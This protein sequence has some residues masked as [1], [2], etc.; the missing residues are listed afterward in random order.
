MRGKPISDI[1][2]LSIEVNGVYNLLVNIN[3]HKATGP[4]GIPSRLLKET[5]YQM[6]PLLTFIFQSSLDQGK[7]PCDWKLANITPLYK[8]E[9]ELIHLTLAPYL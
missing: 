6:A 8:K 3:P 1:Q 5:A 2:Q 9:E 7:P 4:D